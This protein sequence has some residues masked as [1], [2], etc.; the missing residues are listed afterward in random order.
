MPEAAP[1][2]LIGSMATVMMIVS[3]ILDRNER[4]CSIFNLNEPH[5]IF[6]SWRKAV[7]TGYI[8]Y[9]S[10]YIIFVE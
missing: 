7:L 3:M 9:E 4:E 5:I 2:F 10:I 8:V 1:V 6:D